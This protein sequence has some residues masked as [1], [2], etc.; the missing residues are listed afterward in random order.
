VALPDPHIPEI[1]P[2][3]PAATDAPVS[4]IERNFRELDRRL[5]EAVNRIVP[6]GAVFWTGASAAPDGYLLADG[7]A[8]SRTTYADLFA[9]Y[10]T[11]YGTGDGSTTFNVPNLKGKVAVGLDA[12][13]TEFDALAETG[14]AKT[15]TLSIAELPAHDHTGITSSN[16][17][18][19]HTQRYD[20]NA[21][22][23]AAAGSPGTGNSDGSTST[24]GAHT[25]TIPSQGDGTA[26]NNLQPY[27][28]LNG[29]VKF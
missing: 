8:V 17:A 6:V 10:G 2:A 29:I 9:L 23:G 7:S 24:D 19:S 15:H 14:G 18:H 28:V 5:K 26:H 20:V 22:A 21:A 1:P 27:V 4:E 11:S 3:V 16:G 25:H 13:Q 12:A